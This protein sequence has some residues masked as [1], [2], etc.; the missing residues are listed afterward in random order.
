MA[1]RTSSSSAAA[2]RVRNPAGGVR[3]T[4]GKNW[5]FTLFYGGLYV[6]DQ[7]PCPSR[8]EALELI[9]DLQEYAD[10]VVWGDEVAPETGRT[11][12]QCYLQLSHKMRHSQLRKLLPR[13]HIESARG[14]DQSNFEYCTKGGKFEQFGERRDTTGGVKG[15]ELEQAR[16]GE[17]RGF[18]KSGRLDDVNDQHFIQFYSTLKSIAKDNMVMPPDAA[19]VTGVWIWGP[20]GVGKSHKA[21][22]DYP[23][24]Y[25]K[26]INKWWDGFDPIRHKFVI[27][28]DLSKDQAHQAYHLKIWADKYAFQCESKFGAMCIRPEKIVVTSNYRIEDIFAGDDV[29]VDALRRR[30]TVIHMDEPFRE[31]TNKR[32][33]VSVCLPGQTPNWNAPGPSGAVSVPLT[34]EHVTVSPSPDLS[35]T[36]TSPSQEPMALPL[37]L[38]SFT[39]APTQSPPGESTQ[40]E[41]EEFAGLPN[42]PQ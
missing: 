32:Q 9:A 23:G 21:R 30:F 38:D 14:D 36:A 35:K 37:A 10:Y 26:I 5:V 16:W 20:P 24:A 11:H 41:E 8:A 12:F 27:I 34:S 18:A 2:P 1:E 31:L 15:R 40:E 6:D 29:L 19:D 42:N 28:D 25:M 7:T 3:D 39:Q 4:Q 13:T 17:T 22:A 33:R